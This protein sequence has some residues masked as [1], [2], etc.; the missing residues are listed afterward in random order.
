[1][2][3]VENVGIPSK[4]TVQK[5]GPDMLGVVGP[6]VVGGPADG[7]VTGE[8]S[9]GHPHVSMAKACAIP[10]CSRVNP[11]PNGPPTNWASPHVMAPEKSASP[12]NNA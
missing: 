4:Q 3:F 8:D 11:V 5:T 10:H 1:M 6:P 9:N 2:V 7:A 12:Y